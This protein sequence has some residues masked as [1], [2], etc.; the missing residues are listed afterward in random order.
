MFQFVVS[1]RYPGFLTD[2][3]LG[4]LFDPEDGGGTVLR[5]ERELVTNFMP[6]P[7]KDRPLHSQRCENFF[8]VSSSKF[9]ALNDWMMISELAGTWKDTVIGAMNSD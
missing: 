5:N 3:F 2:F 8:A 9:I 7:L 1:T 6:L 4:T